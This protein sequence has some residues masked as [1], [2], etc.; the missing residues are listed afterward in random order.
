MA[1]LCLNMIVK[2]EMANLPRCLGALVDHID[3]WVIADTGSTDGTQAFIRDFFA[4]R[5]IPGELVS[6]PFENFGQAR[7]AALDAAHRSGAGFDYILLCDADMELVVTEPDFRRRLTAAAYSA[8]QKE[9]ISYRNVRLVSRN[10]PA[11]YVGVTHEYLDVQGSVALIDDIHFIDHASGANR[12]GK[13]DRDIALLEKALAEDPQ[14]ARYTYYLAQSYRDAGRD[15]EAAEHYARRAALGGWEE[16]A[17]SAKLEEARCYRRLEETERFI[18]AAMAAMEMRPGRAEAYYELARHYRIKGAH[19]LSTCFSTAGL[20]LPYPSNDMLFVEDFVYNTGLL[21]ELSISGYYHDAEM[22]RLLGHSACDK[23]SISRAATEEVRDRASNNLG[24]YINRQKP[25]IDLADDV[26]ELKPPLPDGFNPM[27]PTITNHNGE[28]VGIIRAVNYRY[29]DGHNIQTYDGGP[30]K[31]RNFYFRLDGREIRD[32]TEIEIGPSYPP[33]RSDRVQGIEDFR[34][35]SHRGQLGV[36]GNSR[37]LSRDMWCQQVR[38]TLRFTSEGRC[39]FDFER[40][41]S[42]E[43]SHQKNWMPVVSGDE[44]RFVTQSDPTII[45]DRNSNV[46]SQS[47]SVLAGGTFRGGSQLIQI[48]GGWLAIIHEVTFEKSAKFYWH[49]L[50]KID[51]TLN[52]VGASQRL[53]LTA[54]AIE[55]CAGATLTDAVPGKLAIGIG[56]SDRHAYLACIPMVKIYNMLTSVT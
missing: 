34:I 17:W 55:F 37:E 31:T 6:V 35:Y 52:L 18:A 14:N 44:V 28:I 51:G 46:L 22:I 42:E 5:N 16:E 26:I 8:L 32:L 49:R 11:R 45:V 47:S 15:R 41:M 50:T 12:A 4:S 13:F 36:I 7:N 1:K 27:N 10:V 43:G 33:V 24:F 29:I 56:R 54:D 3:T 23:L 48:D 53:K 25:L 30:V 19:V 39:I 20:A 9:T 21:E 2:N 40:V 38:G